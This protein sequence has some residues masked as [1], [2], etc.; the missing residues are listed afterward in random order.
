MLKKF[1]R[2]LRIE[3]I[4]PEFFEAQFTVVVFIHPVEKR[5]AI[6]KAFSR[7]IRGCATTDGEPPRINQ[8]A[9]PFPEILVCELR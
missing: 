4:G 2:G 6:R 8:F 3:P 1:F 9:V 5:G 7:L